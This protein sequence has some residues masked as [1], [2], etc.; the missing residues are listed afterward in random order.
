MCRVGL[1]IDRN[2]IVHSKARYDDAVVAD[3]QHLPFKDKAFDVSTCIDTLDMLDAEEEIKRLI[4]EVER[5]TSTRAYYH[6]FNGKYRYMKELAKRYKPSYI[7]S[8][9]CL[10]GKLKSKYRYWYENK[11]KVERI[12]RKEAKPLN[13]FVKKLYDER[14]YLG[15]YI[16]ALDFS[17]N[18]F[19]V[20]E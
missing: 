15:S 10:N 5:V 19:T 20:N 9:A 4:D 16:V 6:F 2:A 3:A 1:D 13:E 11:R 8:S 14:V 7:T 12:F 17:V 18:N